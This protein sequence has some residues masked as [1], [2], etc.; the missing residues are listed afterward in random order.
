[1]G[2]KVVSWFVGGLNYQIE[3]HLFPRV[4]HVHY[5]AISKIV[6]QKCREHNLPYH[7][8]DGVMDAVASHFRFMKL[9]GQQQV[10][11]R[12]QPQL[13]SQAA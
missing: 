7:K 1:M 9:L 12:P 4:S 3:H 8:F 10:V 2:N 6:M 11:S 5:P 13:H